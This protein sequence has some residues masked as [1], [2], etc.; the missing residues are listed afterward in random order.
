MKGKGKLSC[1]GCRKIGEMKDKN[2]VE[3]VVMYVNSQSLKLGSSPFWLERL[4]LS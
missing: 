1:H 2:R 3:F 4:F